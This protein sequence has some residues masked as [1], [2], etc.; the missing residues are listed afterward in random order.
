L[1]I[2]V[3]FYIFIGQF[4]YSMTEQAKIFRV[5]KMMALM[6]ERPR[7]LEWLAEVLEVNERTIYRYI[8]LFEDLGLDVD[9]DQANRY[10]IAEYDDNKP[11][12]H[13]TLDEAAL[14]QQLLETGAHSHNLKPEIIRKLFIH[15][16]IRNLPDVMVNA[17]CAL[18]IRKLTHVMENGNK[19]LIKNYHSAHGETIRDRLVEVVKFS[20]DYESID[21]FDVEDETNKIFLIDRMGDV[22]DTGKPA[23]FDEQY[24]DQKQDIF[25]ISGERKLPIKLKLRMRAYLLLRKEFPGSL[26][27][28]TDIDNEV[29][30]QYLFDG[31]V[32]SYS[33][34]GRFVLGLVDH[35]EILET[36]E[37]KE[38]LNERLGMQRFF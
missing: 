33:G 4:S 28:I 24:R 20:D 7:P 5:L 17:R 2:S 32:Y 34:A 15:T 16:S 27:F 31:Y 22:I 12:I 38:H 18:L 25:G 1:T 37:F 36:R 19:A 14:V 8:N 13:F 35:I 11:G 26:P 23:D 30:K 3:N 6:K 10:F 9:K 21:V 29:E